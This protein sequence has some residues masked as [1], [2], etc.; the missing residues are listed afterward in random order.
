[1]TARPAKP[2]RYQVDRIGTPDPP[3]SS[4]FVLDI[5]NDLTARNAVAQ[6]GNLYR[7]EGLDVRAQEAFDAL[8]ET[9]DAHRRIIEAR[10]PK[11][12]KTTKADKAI[13]A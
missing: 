8:H 9:Q 4:Y 2:E 11:K 7:R 1:M 13:P 3:S 10:N 12:K 5:V 6:L